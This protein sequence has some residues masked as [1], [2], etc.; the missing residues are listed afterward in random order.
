MKLIEIKWLFS[1][2]LTKYTPEDKTSYRTDPYT[3]YRWC[4]TGD[5]GWLGKIIPEYTIYK[6]VANKP[7]WVLSIRGSWNERNKGVIHGLYC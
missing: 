1:I 3:S 4:I 7:S 6:I 5:V 2:V